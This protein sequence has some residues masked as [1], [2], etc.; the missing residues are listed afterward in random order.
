MGA[1]LIHRTKAGEMWDIL[2]RKYYGDELLASII[3]TA[4]F[5]HRHCVVLPA[6]LEL[7]IPIIETVETHEALA[8]WRK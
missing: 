6:G 8:P 2:A 3:L 4:N 1:Y 7:T 5:A